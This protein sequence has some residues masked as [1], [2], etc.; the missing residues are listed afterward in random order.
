[1]KKYAFV[2]I[3]IAVVLFLVFVFFPNNWLKSFISD[4]KV[5]SAATELNPLMFQGDYVQKKI[6]EEKNSFPIYGS[7]ELARFD[8]FHPS[9]YFAANQKGFT[10][11]LYGRGGMQSLIHFM[12][13]ASQ[14]DQL[15]GKKLVFIISPQWFHEEGI[16]DAHFS[17]N[18]SRL[19]AYDLVFNHS[20]DSKL[21]KLAM[22]R[23]LKFNT[24]NRDQVL[25]TLYKAEISN[26]KS[27]RF[28]ADCAKPIAYLNW[29]LLQKKDLY[30]SL[31]G[32]HQRKRHQNP[33]LVKNKSWD[34]LMR[35]AEKYGRKQSKNNPFHI[36]DKYYKKKIAPK[37]NEL[38]NYKKDTSFAESVE[39]KD[40]QMVLDLLK[41]KGAK[42]LFV[43]LPVNG[44]WYDYTGF[45]KEGRTSFYKKIKK[46]VEAAGFPIADYSVHEYDPYFLKDTIHIAWKGW[47]YM[48]RAMENHWKQ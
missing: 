10:P 21:K 29:R 5:Q 16:D 33:Q 41:E 13:F 25:S 8:P 45:P 18:Y 37:I 7:S 17:P 48:D 14:A 27:L 26:S 15:K 42:P 47:V 11:F 46:Q 1:M 24:V 19:Q 22:A 34:K 38:K 9:N 4:K 3:I 23:L 44:K 12:N 28:K 30:Y 6:L 20:I 32:G 40:F 31:Y 39:Y 2:P 35:S 43:T 36:S